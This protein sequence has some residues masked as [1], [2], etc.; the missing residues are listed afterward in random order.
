MGGPQGRS[1]QVR[2][3]SLPPGFDPRTVKPVASRYTDWATGPTNQ[4]HPHLL[5]HSTQHSPYSEANQSFSQSG[6]S[7][8]FMQPEGSLPYLQVPA[9]CPYPESTPS[10]PHHPTNILNFN[11]LFSHL[12]LGFPNCLFPSV[13]P[14]TPST[15][16][17]TPPYTLHA[18]PIS[19]ARLPTLHLTTKPLCLKFR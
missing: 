8:H 10:S 19:S 2:N 11:L 15:H 7:P 6:Y 9:I 1:G 18:L 14:P 16:L 13:F 3:I 17:S 4:K 5:P 12:R